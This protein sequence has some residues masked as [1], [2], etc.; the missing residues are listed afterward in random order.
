MKLYD[1]WRSSSAWRVRIALAWKGIAYERVAVNL[2]PGQDQQ[3][4][5]AFREKNPLGQVP[6]LEVE[7]PPPLRLTQS[8]AILE[9]LEET[10]PRPPLLPA[11]PAARARARALALL[12]VSGIQPLQNIRL[13]MRLKAMGADERA[14]AADNIAAGLAALEIEAA[15]EAAAPGAGRFLVGDA[16]SF[17]DVCLVPQLYNARRWGVDLQPM[18]RLLAVEAACAALPA[19]AAA[20]PERQADAPPAAP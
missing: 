15:A 9:Y 17:A 4:T 14:F 11:D 20:V 1:Y 3:R 12:V 19:F 5:A 8:L 6:V 16:A 2:L 13:L 10:H 18:P 7:G